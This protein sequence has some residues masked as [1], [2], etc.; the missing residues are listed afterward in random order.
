M[1]GPAYPYL[2]TSDWD[3]GFRAQ[4]LTDLITQAPGKIDL[5]YVQK[6]QFDNLSLNA[7]TLVPILRGL[8]VQWGTPAEAAAL[9]MLKKWD[10]HETMSSFQGICA[11]ISG[12]SKTV[13]PFSF[14]E[15]VN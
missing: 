3:Y 4:R 14:C 7:E 2:I 5:A 8:Q 10:F 13:S 12:E 15:R 9:D 1:V 6:M 11:L